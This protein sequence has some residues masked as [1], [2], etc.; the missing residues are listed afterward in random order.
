MPAAGWLFQPAAF[1]WVALGLGL[2]IGSF[3]NVVIH[4]LPRMMEREWR[5]ECAEILGAA[6][7][8]APAQP[9]NLVV[10]AS[11]CPSCGKRISPLE[12]I[13]VLSWLALRGRCAG[14]KARISMKYPLVELLAGVAAAGCAVRFGP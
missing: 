3:L 1:P 7:P 11:A 4:R 13:P 10:P 6:A 2:C 9:Y 12:N 14:C 5:A 8:A